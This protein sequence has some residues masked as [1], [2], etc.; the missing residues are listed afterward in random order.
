MMKNNVS[1]ILEHEKSTLLYKKWN[2]TH[3]KINLVVLIDD[4]LEA[5]FFGKNTLKWYFSTRKRYNNTTKTKHKEKL[6][7]KCNFKIKISLKF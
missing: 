3:Q 6:R 2:P 1:S 4:I 5:E 7:G